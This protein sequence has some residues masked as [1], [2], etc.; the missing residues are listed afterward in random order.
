MG[1][2]SA[3]PDYDYHHKRINLE[4]S[5]SERDLGVYITRNLIP[6][7]HLKRAVR[8]VNFTLA[9]INI[10]LKYRDEISRYSFHVR[11]KLQCASPVWSPHLM[12]IE[13]YNK[14]TM[15]GNKSVPELSYLA[16]GK[17]Q[18]SPPLERRSK[19][20]MITLYNFYA[21]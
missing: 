1:S 3:R 19:G 15:L 13:I 17:I 9:N 21:S 2:S 16:T 4:E 5:T 20:D 7:N 10:A 6:E 12:N 18:I 14:S 11:S 8:R